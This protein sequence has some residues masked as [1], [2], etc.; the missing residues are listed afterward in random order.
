MSG[1]FDGLII[2]IFFFKITLPYTRLQRLKTTVLKTTSN[3][4][5]CIEIEQKFFK[6]NI[7][8]P[9]QFQEESISEVRQYSKKLIAKKKNQNEVLSGLRQQITQIGIYQITTIYKTKKLQLN[10]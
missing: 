3:C 4:I 7:Y 8:F 10:N 1:Q 5:T 2:Y 9:F 6:S